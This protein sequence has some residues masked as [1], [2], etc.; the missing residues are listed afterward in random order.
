MKARHAFMAF[1]LIVVALL[2][3]CE[4]GQSHATLRVNLRKDRSIVP[5]GYPLEIESYRITGDGPG[6]ESFSI[7]TN[8]E[9]ISLEGLVIGEWSILAE[10]LNSQKDV[11][12]T[13]STTHRLSVTNGSC[14]I[15]LEDL[16]GEG[17]LEI[18]LLWDPV[19]INNEASIELELTPQYG[20]KETRSLELTSFD[21]EAGRATYTGSGYASGSYVLSARLFDGSVQIAGFVEAVRIAGDQ[22]SSGEIEFDLDKYPIDPGT[23]ELEDNTGVPVSCIITG[24]EDT[25][26]ADI[27]IT[28]TIESETDDV[29]QFI[30]SWYL[31]GNLIGTGAEV[32]FTPEVGTHR[33]DVVAST[34][35]LGTSGSQS[36]NFEAVPTADPG[37]PSYG[38]IIESGENIEISGSGVVSFLP[39]GNAMI[40]SNAESKIYIASMIRSNIDVQREYSFADLDIT[41]TIVDF[42]AMKVSDGLSKV[43]IATENPFKAMVF[44]YHP[45]TMTLTKY[46]EAEPR[47]FNDEEV[48]AI[49][50]VTFVPKLDIDGEI[51][52]GFLTAR[53]AETNK[54][55]IFYVSL[56]KNT[57]DS[58]LVRCGFISTMAYSTANVAGSL[59]STDKTLYQGHTDGTGLYLTDPK[60][61]MAHFLVKYSSPK[62][63]TPEYLDDYKNITATAL[64][65]N[66]TIMLMGTNIILL[67]STSSVSTAEGWAL[68]SSKEA[69]YEAS[70]LIISADYKFAYCID[71]DNDEIVTMEI[72]SDSSSVTEIGR[73]KLAK[74]GIDTIA[75]SRSGTNLIA[76]DASNMDSVSIYRTTR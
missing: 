19:R 22:T 51:G 54:W 62:D 63:H 27:P 7:E 40:V 24:I 30:I 17:S 29:S 33:L 53:N 37:V 45:S 10:G 66:E 34:S 58:E 14:T 25:V 56:V 69:G 6:D 59:A 35:K 15:V 1:L 9:T 49:A 46:S 26:E 67:K 72:A 70:S 12:V 44:N 61:D 4:Q 32:E 71:I 3:A 76:Y 41:G 74:D 28:V 39:D 31:D 16:T 60:S 50:S 42:E 68:L 20:E 2:S 47:C 65:G 21:T 13:G 36:V 38:N 18:V 23:L 64:I 43:L 75:L 55:S 52:W 48:N 73:T 5:A 57:G 11:L 8:K